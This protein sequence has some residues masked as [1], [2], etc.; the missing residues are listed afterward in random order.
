VEFEN[1]NNQDNRLCDLCGERPAVVDVMF[2]A[3]SERRTGSVCEEC[4]RTAVAQQQGGL[5]GGQPNGPF[6]P[7][8]PG[9]LAGGQ[10]TR[11]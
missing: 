11:Q 5:G 9:S 6:G 10:A 3:G 4:A 8:F 7:L 1:Q 2:V